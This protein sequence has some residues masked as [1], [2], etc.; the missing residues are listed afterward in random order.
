M[1]IEA[2]AERSFGER[3][4]VVGSL[5]PGLATQ[6]LVLDQ[7]TRLL[8][9]A[10]ASSGHQLI[11]ALYLVLTQHDA[12]SVVT[13][14]GLVHLRCAECRPAELAAADQYPC[15]TAQALWALDA[16]IA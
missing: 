1:S 13:A 11:G 8:R 6:Q 9:R 4:P 14:D 2:S 10:R 5:H 16:V 3:L 15:P 7:R 12:E